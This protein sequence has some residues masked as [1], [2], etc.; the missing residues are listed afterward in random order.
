VQHL[1]SQATE[2]ME[3]LT[4][5]MQNIGVLAQKEAIAMKI[6]TVVTMIFLPA[7][8]VSVRCNHAI[9]VR[10]R[11]T[12]Q[13]TFFSTDVVHYQVQTDSTGSQTDSTAFSS[14]AMFRW[15]EVTLPLTAFTMVLC[16]LWYKWTAKKQRSKLGFYSLEMKNM[17]V[18]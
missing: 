7:T 18:V 5:N 14:L 12:A 17:E 6:V 3:K 2:K 10:N 1:Q 11:L 4:V 13:P 15:L 8:F 9:I 16:W